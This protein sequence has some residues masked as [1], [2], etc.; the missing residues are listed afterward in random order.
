MITFSSCTLWYGMPVPYFIEIN[1]ISLRHSMNGDFLWP[2]KVCALASKSNH[3][4]QL[5]SCQI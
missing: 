3:I 2:F 1:F 5:D 4:C